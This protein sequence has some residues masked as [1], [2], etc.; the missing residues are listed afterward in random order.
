MTFSKK[1]LPGSETSGTTEPKGLAPVLVSEWGTVHTGPHSARASDA[2]ARSQKPPPAPQ[3][4][5]SAVQTIASHV[6]SSQP[7]VPFAT[8]QSECV[9]WASPAKPARTKPVNSAP[10][11]NNS[12]VFATILISRSFSLR[13]PI[14]LRPL[15]TTLAISKFSLVF[16]KDVSCN[17]EPHARATSTKNG[18]SSK[19]NRGEFPSYITRCCRNPLKKRLN[20][21]N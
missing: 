9:A 16:S 14:S 10:T 17:S 5:G 12:G 4:N 20:W 19:R 7:G 13:P 1:P 18:Q 6:G 8:Q 11:A 15:S 3:Q 21:G 2:Q